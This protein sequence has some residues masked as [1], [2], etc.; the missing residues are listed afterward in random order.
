MQLSQQ[1]F[2]KR[3]RRNMTEAELLLWYH[4]RGHRLCGMKFK[5]Q[6]PLGDFIVDFV[7]FEKKLVIE[8]DGGQHVDSQSD[9]RRDAWLQG[10]GFR[11]LRFWNNEVLGETEAVLEKILQEITPSPQPLSHEGRGAKSLERV[12][13]RC[14]RGLL[15]LDIVLGRFV[16]QRY[17]TMDHEQRVIFDELLDMPD[18]ELWDVIT[19]KKETAHAHQRVVLEW[20]KEA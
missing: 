1:D 11:M 15:E 16:E 6:Q 5:R 14:R 7:S 10:Q 3:L 19:G 12:R 13:W 8:V 9:T 4:L 17:R 18:T 20:L 2:A